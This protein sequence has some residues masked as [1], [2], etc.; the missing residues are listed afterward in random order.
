MGTKASIVRGGLILGLLAQVSALSGA[1]DRWS[2]HCMGVSNLKSSGHD[3]MA[4]SSRGLGARRMPY[5]KLQRARTFSP[6]D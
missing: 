5:V 2:K 6:L 4:L 3:M 1:Q